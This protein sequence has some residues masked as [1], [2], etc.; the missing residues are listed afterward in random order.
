M[1]IGFP[2]TL[3]PQSPLALGVAVTEPWP[4][5][6]EAGPFVSVRTPI[7]TTS[8]EICAS[9]ALEASMAAA[10]VASGGRHLRSIRSPPSYPMVTAAHW[11]LLF[12]PG[13]LGASNWFLLQLFWG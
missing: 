13:P 10:S 8:S 2:S 11:P 9:A 3:P 4:V 1:L 12:L 7:L 5:G 6:V